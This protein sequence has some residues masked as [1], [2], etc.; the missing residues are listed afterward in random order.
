[1]KKATIFLM[2]LSSLAGLA[3]ES[4]FTLKVGTYNICTSDSRLKKISKGQFTSEQRY[5]CNSADAVAAMI[6]DLDCDVIGLQE[7]CDSIWGVKGV[8]DLRDKVAQARGDKSYDWVLYPNTSK[9]SISYDDAIGY[10]KDKLKLVDSGIFWMTENETKPGTPE[11]AP[12]GSSRPMVWATF[13]EKSTGAVF[14]FFSTHLVL[15]S[16]YKDGGTEYNAGHFVRIVKEYFSGKNPSIVV[17]DFNAG[18][19]S[20]ALRIMCSDKWNDC[21]LALVE[22]GEGIEEGS[23]DIGSQPRPDESGLSK[24]LID[25]ILFERF[26]PMT[27]RIDSRKFPTADGTMHFPSDHLP[28]VATFMYSK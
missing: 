21:Y 17:G 12:K 3:K 27:Y 13:K 10:N 26:I 14:D 9:G 4:T 16:M 15:G 5:W 23:L 19:N 24:G 2:L 20:E 18:N 28:V 1:M 22:K 6:A 25:H 11:G 7:I 8:N